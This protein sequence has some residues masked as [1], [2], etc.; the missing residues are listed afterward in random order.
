MT[1]SDDTNDADEPVSPWA[2]GDIPISADT[3]PIEWKVGDEQ[4][5]QARASIALGVSPD[6]ADDATRRPFRRPIVL[7][8]VAAALALLVAVIAWPRGDNP[9]AI[10]V[11][12]IDSP[13]STEPESTTTLGVLPGVL[14]VEQ[15][16]GTTN[17]GAGSS[18]VPTRLDLPQP[19]AAI[20]QPTEIIMQTQ[21]GRVHTLSLP[22]GTVRTV[23]LGTELSQ[24][25]GGG[26]LAVAPDAAFFGSYGGEPIIIPR[27][28][29]PIVVDVSPFVSENPTQVLPGGWFLDEDGSTR[30]LATTYGESGNRVLSVGLDG[31]M[32]TDFPGV[33][34][35]QFQISLSVGGERFIDDAGGVYRI[36]VDG[37]ATRFAEGSLIAGSDDRLLIRECDATRSCRFV[38]RSVSP[39]DGFVPRVIDD[40]AIV[41]GIESVAFYYGARLSPDGEVLAAVS[42]YS[43][44]RVFIDFEQ[45]ALTPVT[46]S[47]YADG[48]GYWAPDSSGTFNY[49]YES[50]GLVFTSRSTGESERF[51]VELGQI[52]AMGLRTPDTELVEES[53]F[54]FGSIG[55]SI[56]PLG[57]VDIDLVT[58]GRI[59]AMTLLDLDRTLATSWNAPSI[60]GKPPSLFADGDRVVVI[61]ANSNSGYVSTYGATTKIAVGRVPHVP[62][63][64]GP[65][66]GVLWQRI[67]SPLSEVN[68]STV[69]FDGSQPAD[70]LDI[71][72][73]T[74]ELIGSDAA[75]GIVFASGGD[76]Y[77]S[78]GSGVEKLTNGEL[79]A[80]GP[81]TAFV[82]ECDVALMCTIVGFDRTT[83]D[84]TTVE[85]NPM[86]DSAVGATPRR[87]VPLDGSVSPD[88]AV[89]L[90]PVR[91]TD[92]E[93]AV[94]T[95]T[96]IDLASGE[97]TLVPTPLEGQPIV[98]NATST[99]AAIAT[100]DLSLAL[101]ERATSSIIGVVTESNVSGITAVGPEF[102]AAAVG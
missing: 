91:A 70:P 66:D 59:G 26:Q 40:P 2:T 21:N 64:A 60:T 90:V 12:T 6:Q 65:T 27:S 34:L 71:S 16:D 61:A 92:G 62:V 88:D 7:G 1:G 14:G 78:S 85:G 55:F 95:W 76:I 22:S 41:E 42:P 48:A 58:V 82:K 86:L 18:D 44:E 17:G 52:V 102:A 11:D 10:P 46:L 101:Y 73:G 74:G 29:P 75:G 38:V 30:F 31:A 5:R 45:G 72:I 23:D 84:R 8:A 15:S 47:G 98:W 19:V 36:A 67:A 87:T 4:N 51:G 80:I 54:A 94:V 39:D 50:P 56:A 49:D 99:Y 100:G 96:M 37:S 28:G 25:I 3:P 77:A 35:P 57:P 97:T 93:G 20:G 13:T 81:R 32:D 63:M 83:G 43:N 9:S 89:V 33:E 69:H 24:H 79:L 53:P 68:Q